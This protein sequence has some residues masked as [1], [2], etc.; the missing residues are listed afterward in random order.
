[1]PRSTMHAGGDDQTQ[2]TGATS[3]QV[4]IVDDDPTVVDLASQY[5]EAVLEEVAVRTETDPREAIAVVEREPID[6]VVCD[7]SMPEID[8]LEVL[9]AVE[10]GPGDTSFIFF[11]GS[12]DQRVRDRVESS[13]VDRLVQKGEGNAF[14]RLAQ[15]IGLLC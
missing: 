1:M 12:A 3:V 11:T 9:S 10:D 4:L 15:T 7:Y 13:A 6:C 8:G 5:L 2:A 14:G